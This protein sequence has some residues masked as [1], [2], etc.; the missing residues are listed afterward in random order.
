VQAGREVFDLWWCVPCESWWTR[1]QAE[2]PR[3]GNGR[4]PVGGCPRCY[5]PLQRVKLLVLERQAVS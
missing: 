4:R 2:E 1:K 5:V 3:S